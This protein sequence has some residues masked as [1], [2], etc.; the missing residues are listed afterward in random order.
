MSRNRNLR[1]KA[2]T[3]LSTLATVVGCAGQAPPAEVV[4]DWGDDNLY[5]EP[6]GAFASLTAF[7]GTCSFNAVSGVM[8]V[9]TANGES[10]I[11]SKRAVDSAIL[12]NGGL[13]SAT[14]VTSTTL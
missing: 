13:C 9:T 4:G 5:P 8:S 2:A 14:L 10:V 11:V 12:L 6:G 1:V 3:A 7:A